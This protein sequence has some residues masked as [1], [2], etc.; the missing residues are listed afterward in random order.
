[1]PGVS[2]RKPCA[3]GVLLLVL[4]AAAPAVH[5]AAAQTPPAP[6][7]SAQDTPASTQDAAP[8]PDGSA[9]SPTRI[10]VYLDCGDC[11]A[12]FLRQEITWVDF[13]RQP[14]DADV[15][16]LSSSRSTG[17]GGREVVLRFVGAGR[18]DGVDLDLRVLTPPDETENVRR[19]AV[20]ETVSVGLLQYLARE[21]LP[22]ELVLNV[23]PGLAPVI[24][25]AAQDRWNL[26]VF[27][28][29]GGASVDAEESNREA[30]W[31]VNLSA[32]RV[33]NR[34]KTSFGARVE[35]RRETFEVDEDDGEPLKVRRHETRGD[36]FVA[37]SLGPHWSVG[38]DGQVESS[39]FGNT[40]LSA[41]SAPAVEFSIFPYRD[42]ATRQFTIEYNAGIEHSEYE[43]V[44][45]FGQTRETRGRHELSTRFD[46]RQPWG[47]IQ[48]RVE[49]SQYLHDL[50]KYRLEFDGN[51]TV[52]LSRGF[53]VS[54]NASA[55]RI[56][57]QISLPRR[58]A[59]A[60]EVLLELREL[61]SGYEYDLSFRINYSFG[62]IFNNVVNPR[63]GN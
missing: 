41:R 29:S 52:R 7:A 43:E 53:S 4:L 61:Q 44:T 25:P 31:D 56:R 49:W 46:Q 48:T 34:W 57:D 10:R 54:V 27:R 47:S 19:A 60:E 13:V 8:A 20:L 26:W 58:S 37:R 9:A 1:M 38:I 5:D 16:L 30:R 45:L 17:S 6:P 62:S 55:S 3:A 40:S 2:R 21:G 32:D 39:S 15:D 11:F 36:W 33:T 63:F 12:E 50:G 59:T 22:P 14:Q 18:F 51:A 24:A 42:Y 28:V 23:T 35:R